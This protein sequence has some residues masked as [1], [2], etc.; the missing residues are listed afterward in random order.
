MKIIIEI[1]EDGDVAVEYF[2]GT[3]EEAPFEYFYG[4]YEDVHK[5][6][7]IR[8]C[9]PGGIKETVSVPVSNLLDIETVTTKVNEACF[10]S[11]RKL[12]Y[13]IGLED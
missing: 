10:L 7:I 9:S 13:L 6:I 4:E 2:K 12:D 5:S 8:C 1:D 11:S 3:E